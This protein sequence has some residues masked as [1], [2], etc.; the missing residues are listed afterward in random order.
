MIFF[1]SSACRWDDRGRFLKFR[2]RSCLLPS[3][4]SHQDNTSFPY[5]LSS[6][7]ETIGDGSGVHNV[8]Q[9]SQLVILRRATRA[10]GS[11]DLVMGFFVAAGYTTLAMRAPQND[12]L[13]LILTTSGCSRTVPNCNTPPCTATPCR[14]DSKKTSIYGF[15]HTPFLS[16]VYSFPSITSLHFFTIAPVSSR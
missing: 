6:L 9:L 1:L 15:R 3:L 16:N 7:S 8:I 2:N 11:P 5:A 4:L 14:G 12:R 10:E 13:F